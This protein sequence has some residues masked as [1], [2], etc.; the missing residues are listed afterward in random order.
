MPALCQVLVYQ[1]VIGRLA[2]L[3]QQ[4]EGLAPQAERLLGH[5]RH[6]GHRHQTQGD[7]PRHQGRVRLIGQVIRT[8]IIAT[9]VA[10]EV[11]DAGTLAV[12]VRHIELLART[13]K[14]TATAQ[15]QNGHGAGRETPVV[16]GVDEV[17]TTHIDR[18]LHTGL[19]RILGVG[20]HLV[21]HLALEIAV[22]V[23]QVRGGLGADI[24][25]HPGKQYGLGGKAVEYP[26]PQ[27]LLVLLEAVVHPQAQ[28]EGDAHRRTAQ[29]GVIRRLG[30]GGL[31]FLQ[32]GLAHRG[33]LGIIHQRGPLADIKDF[34]LGQVLRGRAGGQEGYT[35]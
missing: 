12:Q 35:Y 33:G 15:P 7:T 9:H 8:E 30:Q 1:T 16:H 25:I 11:T 28:G 5:I 21:S 27:P 23:Q 18:I 31:H 29:Q 32:G 22:I 26:A 19:Q 17:R 4:M 3:A 6:P 20:Q 14:G 34:P 10:Q 2:V 24:R 13:D